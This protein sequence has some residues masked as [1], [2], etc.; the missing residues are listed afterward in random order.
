[1]ETTTNHL[2]HDPG[3]ND[4]QI[5]L[6]S[7]AHA[8]GRRHSSDKESTLVESS[9][10]L[11]YPE[12]P[13]P[14]RRNDGHAMDMEYSEAGFGKLEPEYL[15]SWKLVLVMTGIS[16]VVF[17]MSL[18]QAFLLYRRQTRKLTGVGRTTQFWRRRFPRLRISSTL[19]VI[20]AGMEVPTC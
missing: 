17:C 2:A 13:D 12:S 10:A 11:D 5:K 7:E 16:L 15:E 20:S 6:T 14:G 8:P 19:W 3:P 1:M 18:V 4:S 9:P